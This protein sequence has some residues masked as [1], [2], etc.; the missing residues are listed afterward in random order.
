[1]ASNNRR[2]A[3]TRAALRCD[4]GCARMEEG[5]A[6][7]KVSLRKRNKSHSVIVTP[8]EGSNIN[9][10]HV[11]GLNLMLNNT[12]TARRSDLDLWRQR[13]RSYSLQFQWLSKT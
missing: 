6:L 3:V 12:L 10:Q 11:C 1:M 2:Q 4:S 13:H 8:P 5:A 7:N 9:Q